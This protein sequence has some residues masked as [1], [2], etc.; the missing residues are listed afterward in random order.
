MKHKMM[1]LV[2]MLLVS[3]FLL[4]APAAL[5]AQKGSMFEY[6][7]SALT[8]LNIERAK[9]RAGKLAMETTLCDIAQ[10]LAV[11]QNGRPSN[12][13]WKTIFAQY[14]YSYVEAGY[15]VLATEKN[16]SSLE[17]IEEF[18]ADGALADTLTY[19]RYTRSGL[20]RYEGKDG[21]YQYVLVF[22]RPVSSNLQPPPNTAIAYE[23]TASANVNVRLGA[24]TNHDITG[25]LA[26]GQR[27]KVASVSGKWA[28]IVWDNSA[29]AYVHTN[30]LKKAVGAGEATTKSN[31]NVREGASL[32]HKVLTMLKKGTAVEILDF[33]GEWAR[34]AW[35]N[36]SAYIRADYLV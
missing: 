3:A 19:P 15:V 5:A 29:F 33:S 22:T 31:V 4:A 1:R 12:K 21:I 9:Q 26:K 24:G 28:K 11:E 23:A 2:S 18:L 10:Q 20:G 32:S 35:E 13:D 25:F 34:I 30:Y 7:K 16:L 36:G 8:T 17:I 14:K 6:Q 27:V